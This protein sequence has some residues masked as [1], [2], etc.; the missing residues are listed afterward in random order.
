MVRGLYGDDIGAEVGPEEEAKRFDDI[1]SFWL[2]SGEAQLRELL[3]GLQHD[4]VRSEHDSSRLLLVV[5][6]LDGCVVGHTERDDLRLVSFDHSTRTA[7]R[8]GGRGRGREGRKI[9]DCVCSPHL[10]A[11]LSTHTF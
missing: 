4:E 1:G 8:E 7:C 2:P 3:V 9:Y 10:D 5:V 6:D 11:P